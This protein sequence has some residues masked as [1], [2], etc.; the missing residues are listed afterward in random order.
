VSYFK[1]RTNWALN[2]EL[3]TVGPWKTVSPIN[4]PTW[5]MERNPYYW[6]VDTAGNQLPY[7]DRL[8]MGLAENLEVLNL[9]AIAGEY[10]LQERHVSLSKLPV[11]IENQKKGNYSIHLDTSQSGCDAALLVNT[12]YEADPEIAK[13]L[14]NKDFRH[15]LA[16][17][18]DRNQ[19]NEA[20]WLGLGTP[21]STAPAE[22]V[23]IS[24]GKEYRKKWG[25]LDLKQANALLDKIGL[26]KKDGEGYRQRTDGKGR[27]RIELM[28]VGGQFIPYTQM[29]EMIKQQWVKIGID[30][31]VKET[32]RGLAFTKTA[33]A[34]H[35]IMFWTVGGSENL[36]L[37]PRHVLPV[38]PAE[39][40]L[41]MPF[42]RWYASN[43]AQGKKPTNPEMLRAFDL[44]RSASGKK[45]PERVKIAQEI[46]KIILEECWVIGTVGLSPAFMGVRIVKNNMGNIPMRQTN[47]QHARTPNTSHPATFFFKA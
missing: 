17:G 28:S 10:D 37:F 31:D 29:G 33:N 43:G 45:E 1:N 23:P 20:L 13:W 7:M 8:T 9:R 6:A 4:T 26:A 32:E 5:G 38:D 2:V 47:A 15:A 30:A 14:T 18:I 46:W 25:V 42:A 22:D 35:H 16:L 24:P 34:E 21:G 19:L 44:Y 3:P 11:F 40:H 39:C 12:A 41:G 27:V 36:Y